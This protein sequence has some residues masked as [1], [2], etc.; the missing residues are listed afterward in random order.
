[1][2]HSP[3]KPGESTVLPFN[4]LA[5]VTSNLNNYPICFTD[6]SQKYKLLTNKVY[7]VGRKE[8]DIIL[9]NDPAISRKH[10]TIIVNH[11]ENDVV[12]NY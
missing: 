3:F 8:A 12:R 10:A 5:A 7:V 2:K 9:S 1:M 11:D 4:C 6:L